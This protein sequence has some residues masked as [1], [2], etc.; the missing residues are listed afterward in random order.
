MFRLVQLVSLAILLAR[1]VMVYQ[2]VNVPHAI[3]VISYLVIITVDIYAQ[4][5][6]SLILLLLNV[7]L[8]TLNVLS[9]LTVQVMAVLLV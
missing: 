3:K 2:Q 8:V 4:V 9:A 1:H 6:V 5:V 7:M